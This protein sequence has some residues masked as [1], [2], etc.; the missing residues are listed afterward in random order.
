MVRKNARIVWDYEA[1]LQLKEAYIYIRRDSQKN[2]QKVRKDILDI[3][4][5]LIMHPEKHPLD[6]FKLNNDGSYRAFEKHHYRV[7]YRVSHQEIKIISVR[8]TSME[9]LE[10]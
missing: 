4:G 10:R 9:P 6:K 7:A 1:K 8:H 3:V 2:A 5:A